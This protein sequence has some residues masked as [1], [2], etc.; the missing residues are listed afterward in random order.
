MKASYNGVIDMPSS[1]VEMDREEMCYLEGGA[2]IGVD[3]SADQCAAV[4]SA[5]T[6]AGIAFTVTGFA[7]TAIG[8]IPGLQAAFAAAKLCGA[9]AS[10]CTIGYAVFDYASRHNGMHIGYDTSSKQFVYGYN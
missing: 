6:V 10:A 2:F 1:Y 4:A 9:F 8:F 3:L 7:A 5:L